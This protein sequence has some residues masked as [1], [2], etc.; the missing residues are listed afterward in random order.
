MR[1]LFDTDGCITAQKD[2]KYCYPL[3]KI[4]TKN[5]AFAKEIVTILAFLGIPA[6]ICRK[7]N[8]KNPAYDIVVRNKNVQ[9]FIDIIGSH[10]LKNIKKWG[11]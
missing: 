4:C 11:R 6:F 5:Q 9:K 7:I 10:N 2:G 3:V 8:M 1:G